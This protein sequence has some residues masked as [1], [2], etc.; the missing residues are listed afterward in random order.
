MPRFSGINRRRINKKKIKPREISLKKKKLSLTLSVK[1][2]L[3]KVNQCM[4]ITMYDK[5]LQLPLFQGLC[6]TDFTSILE[7]VKLHFQKYNAGSYLMKQ[8]EPC[9]HLVFILSGRIRSEST[10]ENHNYTIQEELDSP[11]VIEPYSLFGMMTYYTASYQALTEVH[12]VSIDKKYILTQLGNYTIFQLNLLNILSNRAQ[13]VYQKLWNAHIG[14]TMD[15]ITNFL[16]LRCALPTGQKILYI[17][18]EDLAELID[19]T[20]INVSKM[21]NILQ[22]QELIEL[23]RKKIIIPDMQRLIEYKE[24]GIWDAHREENE[25]EEEQM[26]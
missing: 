4:E 18:M 9:N 12:T 15:K 2:N 3:N 25:E 11:Y 1:Q 10:D 6:K 22:Q 24:L 5:L 14:T 8:N 19:D 20:R 23:S 13:M 21:L 26:E 16:Q 17:K 7:K